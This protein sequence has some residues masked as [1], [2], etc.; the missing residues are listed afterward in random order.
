MSFCLLCIQRGMAVGK[1][2]KMV[3]R[4]LPLYTVSPTRSFLSDSTFSFGISKGVL[5]TNL[6]IAL[7][8]VLFSL[9]LLYFIDNI[10][11]HI[12]YII[13]IKY[14]NIKKFCYN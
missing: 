11:I 8:V 13:L 14:D 1:Q 12:L 10:Y 4:P 3:H 9:A 7:A 6:P 2:K 5:H